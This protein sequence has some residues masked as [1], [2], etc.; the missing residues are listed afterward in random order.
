MQRIAFFSLLA[1]VPIAVTSPP[2][3]GGDEA[4][5]DHS[6]VEALLQQQLDAYNARDLDAF[7]APYSESVEVY[8]FPGERMLSG[9]REM[10]NR[11]ETWFEQNP[12]LHCEL[13]NRM[14]VG[15]IAV[16]HERV[17]G[18]EGE[19]GWEGLA[20]YQVENGKIAK[21]YFASGD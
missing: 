3:W 5:S 14:V 4:E 1:L 11:Y 21:V 9:K 10:R 17:T 7:L 20:V 12:L 15:N 13:V 2:S 16:D 8:T 18:L 19:R 6:A